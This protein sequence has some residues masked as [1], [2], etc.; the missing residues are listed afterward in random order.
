MP[1]RTIPRIVAIVGNTRRPSKS[2]ALVEA[3]VAEV[4]KHGAADLRLYDLL[5]GWPGLGAALTREALTLPALRIVEAIEAADGLVVGTPVHNGSYTGLFKH[6]LDF[7]RPDALAGKPVLLSAAGG[8][9]RHALVVEHALRPLF[10][11]FPALTVPTAVYAS[12]G[13]F[14]DGH[15]VDAGVRAR[16]SEAAREF[17]ALVALAARQAVGETIAACG[18][19]RASA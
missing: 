18:G 6:L 4:A 9:P 1:S 13:D 12:E 5:D 11:A 7:V 16:V 17:A 14:A 19:G 8:G 10:A 15:L 2:R 3:V